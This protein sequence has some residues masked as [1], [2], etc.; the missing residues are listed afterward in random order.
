MAFRPNE[1]DFCGVLLGAIVVPAPARRAHYQR[2]EAGDGFSATCKLAL[3]MRSE[4]S[5]WR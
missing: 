2:G 4:P 5:R 1:L 3:P